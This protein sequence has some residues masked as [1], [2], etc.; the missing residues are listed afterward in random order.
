MGEMR[1]AGLLGRL[2]PVDPCH[3]LSEPL[4]EPPLHSWRSMVFSGPSG[5]GEESDENDE[6]ELWNVKRAYGNHPMANQ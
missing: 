4:P 3:A 5:C 2:G 1:W 6:G